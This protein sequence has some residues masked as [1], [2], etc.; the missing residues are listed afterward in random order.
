MKVAHQLD[1]GGELEFFTST[2]LTVL[3]SRGSRFQK[4]F[5]FR[6]GKFVSRRGCLWTLADN[7]VVR[8]T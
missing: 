1:L 5:L 7:A 8:V 3:G 4:R 6:C 2:L